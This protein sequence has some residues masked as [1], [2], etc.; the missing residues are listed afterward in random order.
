MPWLCANGS[1]DEQG[2]CCSRIEIQV[3]E[4][5]HHKSLTMHAMISKA[6]EVADEEDEEDG[7]KG[8]RGGKAGNALVGKQEMQVGDR[9]NAVGTLGKRGCAGVTP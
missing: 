7:G 4:A 5:A 8:G 1:H 2:L 3:P 6:Y 9:R